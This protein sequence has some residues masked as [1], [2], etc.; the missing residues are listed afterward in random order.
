[1]RS[2]DTRTLPRRTSMEGAAHR[3]AVRIGIVS[4]V[5]I[6]IASMASMAGTHNHIHIETFVLDQLSTSRSAQIKAVP[7]D[8]VMCQ[9]NC[10]KWQQ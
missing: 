2:E 6:G 4:T 5:G 9:S 10:V 7:N 1:M 3:T 8:A